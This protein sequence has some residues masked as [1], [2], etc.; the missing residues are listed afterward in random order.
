VEVLT[1][2][3]VLPGVIVWT[4]MESWRI[5]RNRP[6]DRR[7][8]S[9][10]LSEKYREAQDRA[11]HLVAISAL[12]IEVISVAFLFLGLGQMS[13]PPI[14][15]KMIVGVMIFCFVLS[16]YLSVTVMGYNRPKWIVHPAFRR[17]RGLWR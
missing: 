1:G 12:L 8:R 4:S 17:Q 14:A 7:S 5:W 9:S 13:N 11:M 6:R 3:I 10:V 2:V 15:L 16:S